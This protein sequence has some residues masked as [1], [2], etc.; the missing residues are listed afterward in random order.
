MVSH[1]L[2]R[3]SIGCPEQAN[4]W[5]RNVPRSST[6]FGSQDLELVR[7]FAHVK[8]LFSQYVLNSMRNPVVQPRSTRIRSFLRYF[9]LKQNSFACSSV[10]QNFV[11]KNTQN[12]CQHHSSRIKCGRGRGPQCGRG[13]TK[14]FALS[15]AKMLT[16]S[17][18]VQ[19]R[20]IYLT[21]WHI[22]AFILHRII[23]VFKNLKCLP[24]I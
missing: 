23:L 11:N 7:P 20:D 17:F 12:K 6:S 10:G 5:F 8:Y 1:C 9:R 2:F 16:K 4:P 22:M 24:K 19:E 21:V 3:I 14:G 15:L 13:R 18:A